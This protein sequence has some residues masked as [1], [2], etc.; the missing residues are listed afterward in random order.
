MEAEARE[1]AQSSS[2][3]AAV[4]REKCLGRVFDDHESM[5]TGNAQNGVHLRT[6]AGIV[7]DVDRLRPGGNRS[8]DLRFIDVERVR[9]DIHENR[10]TMPQYDGICRRDK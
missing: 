10:D 9:P 7:N 4:S 5:A 3:S 1:I 8:L 2:L 6:D